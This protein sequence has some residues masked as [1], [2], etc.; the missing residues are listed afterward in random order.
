MD[1]SESEA[2]S[3]LHLA[4]N[5][6]NIARGQVWAC[7]KYNCLHLNGASHPEKLG[8]HWL[9]KIAQILCAEG[10]EITHAQKRNPSFEFG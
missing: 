1:N 8:L 9:S 10:R 7:A 2:A 6:E 4:S 3:L 5:V